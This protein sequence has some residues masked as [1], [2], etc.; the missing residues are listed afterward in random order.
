MILDLITQYLSGVAHFWTSLASTGVLKM[1]LVWAILYWIFSGRRH[2]RWRRRHGCHSWK[3]S[4]G[5]GHAGR[6]GRRYRCRCR[7]TCGGCRCGRDHEPHE[8]HA[9]CGHGHDEGGH[10]EDGWDTED[11]WHAEDG[12]DESWDDEGGDDDEEYWDD[13]DADEESDD[14]AHS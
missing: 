2:R 7:C 6:W 8:P 3:W 10:D 4:G 14:E 1:L 11:G 13:A 5:C 9:D 12:D